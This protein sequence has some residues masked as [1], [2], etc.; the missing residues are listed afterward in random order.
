M[1]PATRS[2]NEIIHAEGLVKRYGGNP[3]VNGVDL[4]VFAGRSSGFS[5]PMAPA[6]RRLWR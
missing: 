5:A 6:K 2:D 3:A 4:T 1:A